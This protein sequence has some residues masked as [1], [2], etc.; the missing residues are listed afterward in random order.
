MLKKLGLFVASLL[1][2]VSLY[3]AVAAGP[4]GS[5]I[6]NQN[7]LQQG[8]TFYISSGTVRNLQTTT[9]RFNDGTTMT[10][11]AS[12]TGGTGSSGPSAYGSLYTKNGA[13]N[14]TNISF[15]TA[16]LT[17]FAN[18]GISTHAVSN[19]T[20]DSV[21]VATTGIFNVYA[22]FVSSDNAGSSNLYYS[23][24]VNGVPS[25]FSGSFNPINYYIP[26]SITGI[27]SLNVGDVVTLCGFAN[28]S[29]GIGL[30]IVDSQFIVSS[31][32]G[33][34]GTTII[35]GGS[36]T[37]PLGVF[38][39]GVQISS[40]T[41]Q[42]NF[43]GNYWD[44]TLG[45]TSTGTVK[46]IGG[47]TNY[48]Q[49]SNSLQTGATAY[50]QF[51]NANTATIISSITVLGANGASITYGV[52][53][54]SVTVNNLTA[55]QFVKTD[56]NKR[57]SSQAQISLASD[58]TGTLSASNFVSTAAYTV[59]TQ[60]FS[61]VNTFSSMT[62]NKEINISS[63]SAETKL[64]SLWQSGSTFNGY[65][66]TN[67]RFFT[68]KDNGASNIDGLMIDGTNRQVN[69]GYLSKSGALTGTNFYNDI[70][71][72]YILFRSTSAFPYTDS[73]GYPSAVGTPSVL[74]VIGNKDMDTGKP[75]FDV[76]FEQTID[77]ITA[78]GNVFRITYSSVSS[79]LPISASSFYGDGGNVLKVSSLTATG[80][81][82]GS[83]T[84]T[85]ITVDAQGRITAA[86]NGSAGGGGSAVSSFTYTFPA[87]QAN[88]PGAN[89]PY[90]SNSTNAASAG[91]FFDEISTQTVT[92]SAM[93]NNYNGGTLYSDIIYTSSATSGTMNWGV[94]I[95]CKTPSVDAL[96]Y[97]TDSFS[98]VNSTS[99]T[100][101]ATSGMAMKAT[102]TLTN[103][104]SCANGDSVRIKLERRA[105][106][107]DTAIGKGR[108]RFLRLYE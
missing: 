63:G 45:G 10:T 102:A 68:G 46:L 83:Y 101:G 30:S 71:N 26:S 72:N 53:A 48:I 31:A 51:L 86:S 11:A 14:Q 60:T 8:A 93:L 18:A 29:P 35:N 76:G 36:S 91:V 15:T 32:G 54:G 52:T 2:G 5:F 81:T 88:L 79:S 17:F 34:G 104:D 49:V 40:P 92:W 23:I 96:D 28:E 82:A 94:Y 21:T 42:I 1:S 7:T 38:K 107:S 37:P 74:N 20:T 33:I 85:N 77:E 67:G 41:S 39:N 9:L 70:A 27:L 6:N 73:I 84:N 44:I 3:A 4:A 69:M 55:S 90:I 62:V 106:E 75:L 16:T 103:Q 19:A 80:V 58:V 50:P 89:A 61:G 87:S 13:A 66:K 98:T 108:V 97:D 78:Y 12:G 105:G 99:V 100:V 47:N 56:A 22:V 24:C 64:T 25:N 43:S 59:S 95:E 65:L 57:L